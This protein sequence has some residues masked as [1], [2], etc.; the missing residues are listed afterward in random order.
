[1]APER[2]FKI[3]EERSM[4]PDDLVEPRGGLPRRQFLIAGAAAGA[5]LA[6]P[7]N[8]AALARAKRLPIASGGSFAHGVASGFPSPK[9]VTLWTRVS[10]LHASSKVTLEVATDSH[11]KHV[12]HRAQP[13]AAANKDFTVHARVA[14]L[15]PAHEYHYRFHT[16]N[17]NS[18]VGKFRTLPPADSN[19]PLR[20]GFYSCQSYE[21]GYFNAQA[22]LAKEK[23]LDLVLCLGDYIYEHHYYDGPAA[24]KDTTGT[25]KDGDVQSLAEYRQK[26]RFYQAD[27]NLQDL[28]AAHP[29]FVIW[30]DHE[31]EDNYAGDQPDSKQSDPTLENSGYPRRVPFGQRR[32]NGY[33]AFFEAMP[34]IAP[35]N[36]VIY[37]AVRLGKMAELFLTD[38]RQYRDPQPC[39]DAQLQSCPDDRAPGRTF[40]GAKQKGWLKGAVPKSKARW[41]LLASETMM[42]ALDS[43]PGQ[44]ANQ[45]QWDGYS[46]E[47]EEILGHFHDKK[48]KNLVVLSGDIHTFVAGNLTTTGDQSGT[49]VGTELVGGSATSL[50]LPE[51]LG[52][53]AATLEALRQSSDPHTIYADFEKRGYCVVT[54]KKNELDGEFKAVG[55]TQQPGSPASSLAKFRVKAGTPKIEKV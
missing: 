4:G 37:G 48:V 36:N 17:K 29:F 19:Q 14:G 32:K 40:L 3:T 53:P 35:K 47:R 5:T 25:N 44:H 33:R 39:M 26:Y 21:A 13:T 20:I 41:N 24:R 55:T 34:R 45:D 30:D 2:R 1:M 18:R 27:K 12:V 43:S 22:G 7:I 23:D 46:A 11:F 49:P 42:M 8:Y 31:V 16:K 52:V 54:V 28:H 10:D 6:V 9:A 50:G 51:E 15:K 38:E